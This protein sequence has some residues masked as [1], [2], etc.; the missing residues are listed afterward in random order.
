MDNNRLTE[1]QFEHIEQIFEDA[2]GDRR[3]VLYEHEV[4]AVLSELGLKTP[5]HIVV[6]DQKDITKN[7]LSL[8]S[9]NRIVLKAV[10]S[11][12]THKK[13]AGAISIVYKD[14]YFIKYTFSKMMRNLQRNGYTVDAILLTDYVEYSKDLGNEIL[15]GFRESEAFGPVISFSK[16][17]TDAEHF[18]KNFSPPNLILAPIDR[19][20]AQALLESTKIHKKYIQEDNSG[21]IDQII[22]AG[23]KFSNLAVQFSNFFESKSRF[24]IKEFEVNPFIFDYDDNFI[25]ID[26]F[27]KFW[28]KEKRII[29]TSIKSKETLTPF[30]EPNGIAIAGISSTDN[31][32]AGN[33]ILKNLIN[34]G[35]DDVFCINIRG[36]EVEVE[37][38]YFKLYKNIL[39]IERS[40]ELA[41]ITVPAE[42][43][44]PV[45]QDCVKKGVKAII[46]IPGGFSEINKNIETELQIREL[47]E[48][49]GIRLM[50][51]NCLGIV[52]AGT[53]NSRGIN[54]FFIPEEKFKIDLDTSREKN[55]AILSQSGALGIT[56]IYN[57]RHAISPK[58]IVSYGNQLDVDPS[59]L[60]QYFEDDP[61]VDVIGFY[62][63]GFKKGA[64][65]K[66]FNIT[67]KSKKPI[68]VYKAGRTEIGKKAAQSHTAS[69]AGEYEVAKAAMKQ[70][71]LIVADSMIDHG[72]F[73]KTFAL[74]NDFR[75]SGK[76]VVVV[77][78]AGYEKT[79]A[80]DNLGELSL[81]K[82]DNNTMDN[83]NKV[84][85]SFVEAD[86]LLDLTAMASDELFERCI[87]TLLKSNSVDA[88]LI[89][90]VPQAMVIH[91][92]DKEIETYKKNIAARIVNLVQ[93]YK[94]PTVASINVVSGSDA[95]YN[96]IGQLLDSGGV[97]TFL[98][99][100]RAMICLNEFIKYRLTKENRAFGE[101]LKE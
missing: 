17:G 28:K 39:E 84:L 74:L 85:P 41:I 7:T 34:M 32:K 5:S 80:A 51:P 10:S 73:I 23:I 12:I 40:I 44:L 36:G 53:N 46:L 93:K 18:A 13:Q 54:T 59:D 60:A 58:V 82:L 63:E 49:N 57:L 27:A 47:V 21:Y 65:R 8:F 96:K 29:S 91:T 95:A 79:Y 72:D 11:E 87:D 48:K 33:I 69:I 62:I 61:M 70:A 98:T 67:S 64:G 101:W 26:G 56:E 4:Y 100:E 14:L 55:V 83:L 2:Y 76:S 45:V 35:R 71:G 15:L 88:M 52:Y 24:V 37:G 97:P 90:I 1:S 50:G 6:R 43:T 66:F 20:W 3:S 81:A 30:F 94:K 92:T 75:V 68:I 19:N 78:N 86:P 22:D 25:A 16:G 77:T 99:A 31:N 9:N 38:K 89:S 42:A